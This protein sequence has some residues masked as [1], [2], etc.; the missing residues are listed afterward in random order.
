MRLAAWLLAA[1]PFAALTGQD[2][3]SREAAWLSCVSEL[4][5]GEVTLFANGTV[6]SR[7]WDEA[8]RLAM[9]LAELSPEELTDVLSRLAGEDLGEVETQR[10]GAAGPWLETCDL[11]LA[12]PGDEKRHVRFGALDVLPL[13]LARTVGIL[14][15][16]RVR[17]EERRPVESLP[18]DYVPERGDVLL[19]RDGARYQVEGLTSDGKGVELLGLDQPLTLYVALDSLGGEFRRL[20][21]RP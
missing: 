5:R 2:D 3:R 6:R 9:T 13:A 7:R 8:G 11:D 12:L 19:H 4:G 21:E 16:L 17:A 18:A 15:E 1:L 20:L 10:G 14:H